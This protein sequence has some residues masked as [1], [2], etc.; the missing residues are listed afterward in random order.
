MDADQVSS[1]RMLVYTCLIYLGVSQLFALT[2]A[3]IGYYIGV[4]ALCTGMVLLFCGLFYFR[5]TGKFR[6]S[7]NLFLANCTF[8]AV[9]GSSYFSGGLYSPVTPW[10][11]LIPVATVQ[12]VGYRR[13]TLVWI[14]VCLAIPIGYGVA[15]L[16]GYQFP[17]HYPPTATTSF[18]VI[19]I[20]ALALALVCTA[21]AFEYNSRQALAQALDSRREVER[22]ARNQERMAER[23]RI[24]RSMHDGVGS[25]ITS[26]MRMVQCEP[27]DSPA[28]AE[29]LNTLRDALDQLKLSID[30]LNQ[31]PGDVA[32]LLANMRYRLGPRFA[33]MGVELQWD[34]GLL[35]ICHSLD[36]QAMNEL[37]F[38]LLESLSNVLQHA[39]ARVLR[40]EGHLS[41]GGEAERVYVRLVDDGDGFDPATVQGSGLAT[42]RERAAAIGAQLRI[43]SQPGRTAVEIQITV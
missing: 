18:M 12:L 16:Q 13:D 23:G 4:L 25:H 43:S 26:A 28:R 31:T 19:S 17:V 24:I 11:V 5:S 14:A 39:H 29:I 3:A 22:L 34:V 37:Q 33:V 40:V 38:M 6:V 35:P 42:M 9:T 30:A 1:G 20:S 8:V 32:A 15:S 10:F 27:A 41:A 21:F 36:A 7:V 2:S